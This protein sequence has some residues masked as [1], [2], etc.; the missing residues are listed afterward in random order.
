VLEV[1]EEFLGE[2]QGVL[3]VSEVYPKWP[4][5]ALG[6]YKVTKVCLR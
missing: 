5:Y 3:E 1:D 2:Y 6:G 4:R